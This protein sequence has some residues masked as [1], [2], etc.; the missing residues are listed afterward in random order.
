MECEMSNLTLADI[1]LYY[2][3]HGSGDPIMLIAGLASDSLSWQSLTTELSRHYCVIVFDNRGVGRTLPHS[4]ESSIQKMADDAIA[5]LD[6]L[7]VSSAAII[8]HSMGGMIAQYMASQYPNR[9]NRL[10]LLATAVQ[11][12]ARNNLLFQDWLDYWRAGLSLD[13][14]FKN[15]FYWIFSPDFFNIKESINTALAF[16]LTYPYPQ[17]LV[18]FERQVQVLTEADLSSQTKHINQP[19]LIVGAE[20]DLIFPF[21]ES[22]R[23]LGE[24]PNHRTA[25]IQNSGHSLIVEQPNLANLLILDFLAKT[26]FNEVKKTG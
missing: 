26:P 24:I 5:I 1:D 17:S 12:S 23:A 25:V 16:A 21:K 15:V 9:V 14:W 18:G 6:H 13:L 8:G 3:V 2:E 4:A 19:T 22:L 7:G 10:I 11:N 20:H